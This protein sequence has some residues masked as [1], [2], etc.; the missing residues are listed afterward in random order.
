MNAPIQH[1]DV[2]AYA[3]GL[4]DVRDR[5]AFETHLATCEPCAAELAEMSG[6]AG[7]LSDLGPVEADVKEGE[8]GG[9]ATDPEPAQVID[10]VRRSKA[11]RRRARRTTFLLAA[12]AAAVLV[13]GGYGVGAAVGGPGDG[14]SAHATGGV[15][16]F[17]KEMFRHGDKFPGTGP[18]GVSG[19]VAVEAK[20]W[21]THAVVELT[22]V[23]SPLKCELIAVSRSGERRVM[24]GWAVPAGDYDAS[25]PSGPYYFH[26]GTAF[27]R[28][29]IA[30]FEIK[31]IDGETLLSVPV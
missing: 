23:R 24:T 31:V 28:D 2:A 13:V 22:G 8:E 9:Q 16:S 15:Q 5:A 1:T 10:L 27:A 30:A 17:A 12:A 29:E 3:L 7:L 18:S 19:V 25:G 6:L 21:G 14:G 4:L 11:A 26:G 20:D